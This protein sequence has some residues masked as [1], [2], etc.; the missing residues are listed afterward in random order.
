MEPLPSSSFC[1]SEAGWVLPSPTRVMDVTLCTQNALLTPILSG[2]FIAVALVRIGSLL[3]SHARLPDNRAQWIFWAK[4]ALPHVATAFSGLLLA[5]HL[6][7]TAQLT[8]VAVFA[9][10][11]LVTSLVAAVLHVAEHQR[12]LAPSTTL[13]L[14]YFFNG[15]ALLW[16]LRA[17]LSIESNTA[18]FELVC[19]VG[20]LTGQFAALALECW[21]QRPQDPRIALVDPKAS[22]EPLLNFFAWGSFLWTLPIL[23][24]GASKYLTLDDIWTMPEVATAN[25]SFSRFM[26]HFDK[27]RAKG[28]RHAL[29]WSLAR[30]FGFTVASAFACHAFGQLVI[31]LVPLLVEQLVGYVA[32]WTPGASKST[33]VIIAFAMF[34]TYFV[35]TVFSKIAMY[36]SFVNEIEVNGALM[37]A[38]YRKTMR[39]PA[40]DRSSSGTLTNH[41]QVD[42]DNIG[43]V[44]FEVVM[45][46]VVPFQVILYLT[47]LY[48]R[49]G[50]AAI[51]S[52]VLTLVAAGV[53]SLLANKTLEYEEALLEEMDERIRLTTEAIKCIRTVKL[54][55][56]TP[57]FQR[58]IE[59]ARSRELG[60]LKGIQ[61][62]M[63]AQV[64][65][66]VLIPSFMALATF[67]LSSVLGMGGNVE[68]TP[69]TVFAV[70]SI[71]AMLGEPIN[72]IIWGFSPIA[73][74]VAG[75]GRLRKFFEC[76]E[77]DPST[78]TVHSASKSDKVAVVIRDGY[79]FWAQGTRRVQGQDGD[80]EGAAEGDEQADP[81][82]SQ[83]QVPSDLNECPLRDINVTIP[84]GALTAIVSTVGQ[85]KSSLVAAMI[86]EIYKARGEVHRYGRVAYVAQSPFIV[87]ASV[88]DNI[89]FGLP[90]D[91]ARYLRVIDACALAHDFQILAKGD[92]TMIGEQGINLSGGQRARI[93]CARAVYCDADIYI[94]DDCLSAV[95]AMVDRHMFQHMLGANSLLKDKTRVLVTHAVQ[96]L[97]E[98][99]HIIVLEKGKVT[100]AGSYG[101]LKMGEQGSVFDRLVQAFESKRQPGAVSAS[102]QHKPAPVTAAEVTVDDVSQVTAVVGRHRRTDSITST[103]SQDALLGAGIGAKHY[104]TFGDDAQDEVAAENDED[105]D[106][107]EDEEKLERGSISTA[108]YMTYFKLCG[109][110]PLTF[111]LL[112][113][114]ASIGM[115]LGVQYVLGEWSSAVQRDPTDVST[116][117]FWMRVF[118]LM[119]VGN[120]ILT[121]ASIYHF[122]VTVSIACAEKVSSKLL[123]RVLRLPMS[124][125]DVTPS[126]RITNRFSKDQ[127]TIDTQVPEQV[128][129]FYFSVLQLVSIIVAIAVATPWFLVVLIP[130]GFIFR[131]VQRL[132]LSTSRELQRL[133]SVTMSPIFQ[134]YSESLEGVSTI[135]AFG[136]ERRFFDT[137]EDKIDTGNKP[138]YTLLGVNRWLDVNLQFISATILLS[139]SLLAAMAPETGPVMI[140]VSLTFAQQIT[141]VLVFIVR[142][143]CDIETDF[144]AFER[145]REYAETTPEAPD[146]TD[147]PLDAAWPAHGAIEFRDYATRYRAGLDLV[148]RNV[149]LSIGGGEKIAIVGRT[150][151]GKSSA[152]ASLFRLME[153]AQG[154]IAVDGVNV[155]N[156]GLLDLRSRLTVLPQSPVIFEASIRENLDPLGA[157]DDAA[158]WAAL[159]AA[160][161]D[162]VIAGMDG[163]LDAKIK[164]GQLSVGE[165]QLLCLGRA[166]LRKTKVL[167]LDES[168]A[169]LDVATDDLVQATIRSEFKECTVL[170]IAHRISTTLDFD[171]VL[172]LSNGDVVEFDTPKALLANP[173][174]M[175]Y[176][177]AKSSGLVH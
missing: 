170:C 109:F 100:A 162:Q 40:H 132:Y 67:S 60:K 155:A 147:Y 82:P 91:E 52:F 41:M 112:L 16:R 97:P 29:L 110:F 137:M 28:D 88:R 80:D 62:I 83:I 1:A 133:H 104:S 92:L 116:P 36:I 163:G 43:R 157:H 124:F 78:V 59:T 50:V 107:D 135:R 127:S 33:G 46:G 174:S 128:H 145:I 74:A 17:L 114:G 68:F 73:A 48:L 131:H 94:F 53:M 102:L 113:T 76:I 8:D 118:I 151:S 171:R 143:F 9:V 136:Q 167:A 123:K 177:L 6:S 22:P 71:L 101:E 45:V 54:Y 98:V 146:T 27:R 93:A 39:I 35:A 66:S 63:A 79:F 7:R 150:G 47:L 37:N 175:Y 106:D 134:A 56:W 75:Y 152:L 13:C 44:M 61:S 42:A 12:S 38:V 169:S 166:L 51:I 117:Q 55:G 49:I 77:M 34:A 111:N 126:G 119:V 72:A 153:S 120:T 23:K 64:S 138:M 26:V 142:A 31:V 125:F 140:G 24:L 161:L 168:S 144:V 96:H 160:H 14:Y 86:G 32:D 90:Y 121:G 158:M 99:D 159:K 95:D 85:G 139:A 122:Y 21:S 165:S 19:Y 156:V 4:C 130:L 105:E 57:F 84:K 173:K 15:L 149:S 2:V 69:Q 172:V 10:C 176:E 25:N 164:P 58:R 108:V 103:G 81:E 70:L 141:F 89:C 87:N 3:R 11:S 148:L 65:F 154:S 129:N 20:I 30:T 5:S 115:T 18:L